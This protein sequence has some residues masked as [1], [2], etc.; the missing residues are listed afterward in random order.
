MLRAAERWGTQM[1][2]EWRNS[3]H[4]ANQT[5][6]LKEF[7]GWRRSQVTVPSHPIS[8]LPPPEL[9][10]RKEGRG[11]QNPNLGSWCVCVLV[12]Q[13]W[14]TLCNAMNY[15]PQGSSVHG[16]FQNIGVGCHS[17]LQG[18]FPS[19]GLNLGLLCLLN[20][21]WILYPLSHQG[22]LE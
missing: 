17:L 16:I 18:I 14:L 12:V 8:H 1:N 19:Q 13:S 5:Q 15:R 22:S 21:R 2:A 20:Y 7:E 3:E 9:L 10:P 11:T 6:L 4:S